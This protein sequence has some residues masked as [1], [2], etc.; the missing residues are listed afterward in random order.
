MVTVILALIIFIPACLFVSELFRTSEQAEE[1]FND[2][3]KDLEDLA[4]NNE[5][6]IKTRLLIIDPK[7]FIAAF[8]KSGERVLLGR[9]SVAG[10]TIYAGQGESKYTPE[11]EIG[12]YFEYP[13]S[14]CQGDKACICLCQEYE[15]VRD[16]GTSLEFHEGDELTNICSNLHC[17]N[18]EKAELSDNFGVIRLHSNE[19]RRVQLKL[20][21]VGEEISIIRE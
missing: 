8:K 17:Q 12:Y 19:P 9:R 2:L 21:K 16:D 5:D 3:I 11:V 13:P 14:N 7:T 10:E 4:D 6:A 20:E 15:D 1:S 18:L